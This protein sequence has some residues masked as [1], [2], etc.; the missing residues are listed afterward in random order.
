LEHL[1]M[2]VPSNKFPMKHSS[3]QDD[4]TE[5][6]DI[7]DEGFFKCKDSPNGDYVLKTSNAYMPYV[8]MHYALCAGGKTLYIVDHHIEGL[9]A[10][11]FDGPQKVVCGDT[12]KQVINR[13]EVP[14]LPPYT[15]QYCGTRCEQAGITVSSDNRGKAL[16]CDF[17]LAVVDKNIYEKG[18]EPDVKCDPIGWWRY[19]L[20]AD[21]SISKWVDSMFCFYE[22]ST[23]HAN[24]VLDEIECGQIGVCPVHRTHQIDCDGNEPGLVLAVFHRGF[25]NGFIQ[26]DKLGCDDDNRWWTVDDKSLPRGANVDCVWPFELRIME[27]NTQEDTKYKIPDV[28]P[29]A[30]S[31][32]GPTVRNVSIVIAIASVFILGIGYIFVSQRLQGP[33]IR[34]LTSQIRY[35]YPSLLNDEERN[36]KELAE[37]EYRRV[38]CE[39][40][41]IALHEVHSTIFKDKDAEKNT[42]FNPDLYQHWVSLQWSQR[43]MLIERALL[44]RAF[45][46]LKVLYSSFHPPG[47]E[48]VLET[49]RPGLKDK[50]ISIAKQYGLFFKSWSV[51]TQLY[52]LSF[53]SLSKAELEAFRN[54]EIRRK[55]LREIPNKPTDAVNE[56]DVPVEDSKRNMDAN[57]PLAATAVAPTLETAPSS[58]KEL[59]DMTAGATMTATAGTKGDSDKKEKKIDD[60]T[61]RVPSEKKKKE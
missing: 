28:D 13:C 38:D 47:S 50:I 8:R 43:H 42:K 36:N 17:M 46:G 40:A 34:M 37:K 19:S 4:L 15:L 33:K 31:E 52:S 14:S 39:A 51:E 30:L 22:K 2:Q 35:L 49:S 24:C 11:K 55:R 44:I 57:T 48:N 26:V 3:C 41:G 5:G 25:P 7:G 1:F 60:R 29:R 10:F 56:T 58:S 53:A 27:L 16:R 45:L 12:S 9:L 20:K 23:T 61:A 59:K 54:N 21:T 6:F 18:K 32:I